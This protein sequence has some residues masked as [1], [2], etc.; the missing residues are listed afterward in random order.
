M[1]ASMNTE[2]EL[3]LVLVTHTLPEGWLDALEGRCRILVGPVDAESLSPDLE[4]SLPEA[5]GLYCLLTIKVDETLLERAPKLKVV[6]NMAVGVDN[7]DLS[8]CTRRSIPVGN[9]PDV[10]T[11]GTADLAFTL[12]LSAARHISSASQDAKE[13]RW[14]TWS[15][16]GWLGKDL[17]GAALGIVGL[18]KIGKAVAARGH[19][20][21]MR[22]IYSDPSRQPE[23]ED[24]YGAECLP[25]EEL[26]QKSDFVSLH[27]PL[28][29]ETRHLINH[30]TLKLMKSG[31][32]LVNTARGPIV[33]M[34]ALATAL[35][36]NWIHAAALD[37]TDPEPLPTN[38]PLFQLSN[39]LITPHIGSATWHTRHA[40]AERACINLLAGLNGEKLPYCVNPEVY[41]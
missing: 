14:R 2:S 7:I 16:T 40:M 19:A 33:D 6:S 24:R 1:G 11:D 32:I 34:D 8:A 23:F 39:C 41:A 5:E 37:V 30:Q 15:P 38:H 36:E 17:K 12:L 28:T 35:K 21:G 22:I 26:L 18:G 10:L 13:G 9:T 25:I 31:A 4:K 27:T 20:F 29:S 3:P